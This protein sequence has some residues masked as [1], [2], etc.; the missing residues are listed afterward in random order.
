MTT[1]S[2]PSLN[3]LVVG[4]GMI[5]SEVILPTLFRSR[6]EG[7]ISDVLIATRRVKTIQ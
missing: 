1:L 2:L 7:K 5:S 6:K 3:A 4:G